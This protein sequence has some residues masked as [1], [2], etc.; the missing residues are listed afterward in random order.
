M[1]REVFN[2]L[3]SVEV[4]KLLA[5]GSLKQHLAKA[6]R[7][8][9]ILRSIYGDDVDEVKLDLE[10]E[11]TFL[12][13]R[14]LFF[15]NAAKE[16]SRDKTPILHNGECRC[17]TKLTYWLFAS[18]LSSL[19][20]EENQWSQS[21]QK[22]YSIQPEELKS[23]LLEGIINNSTEKSQQNKDSVTGSNSQKSK[24]F[25][26]VLSDGRLFAVT[27]RN[28]Q[29]NDFQ[30]LVNLGWLRTANNKG[31][32]NQETYLKIEKFPE[33]FLDRLRK[34]EMTSNQFTNEELSAFNNSLSQPINGVQRFFIHAEY[35]VHAKRTDDVEALQ[36]QLKKLW[37]H[38]KI[39]LVKLT[40]QSVKLYQ[41]T[42]DCIV[43]PVCIYYYQRAPYLFAYGQ[44]PKREQENSW[45]QIN[46]YDYRLDRILQLDELPK[47]LED[48]NIP[49][50]FL[51]KCQGKYPP[52]PDDI[53]EKMS[54]A[55]GF[56]I[57]Q[58]QKLLVLRFDYY[59]H[60]NNIKGT[61]RD[62]MFTR[63]S[64]Q[65][66]EQLVKSYTS[67]ASAEQKY[68]LSTVRSR[69]KTDIYCKV[70]YR[71]DDNNIVMRLRA[72]GPKVEVILPWDLRHRMTTDIEATYKFYK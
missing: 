7:L 38:D 61:E 48:A 68:L 49:K 55:W 50:Q 64:H 45:S 27:S 60:E 1:K 11:F 9:V 22:Y 70:N 40:Y 65:Q 34:I 35:I 13:W 57:H 18:C 25:S 5:P 26:K 56:D 15:L 8:W 58:P 69:S 67:T 4:L 24:R 36:E 29:E 20:I 3:P 17:A 37:Q 46:W 66:V 16:H 52:T 21:F 59:F 12:Q 62:E 71:A 33:G 14:D 23:L 6:V 31:R 43:Y 54:E 28:L 10:E 41:D 53:K 44:V 19:N 2:Y 47:D 72:W 51:D 39:P 42:V 30:C 63:I 32:K